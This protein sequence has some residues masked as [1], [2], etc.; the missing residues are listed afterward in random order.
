MKQDEHRINVIEDM[1][2]RCRNEPDTRLAEVYAL[3]EIARQL[4]R[5]GDLYV[6]DLVLHGALDTDRSSGSAVTASRTFLRSAYDHGN[7]R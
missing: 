1:A 3:C 7:D 2:G 6:T 5:L 4:A